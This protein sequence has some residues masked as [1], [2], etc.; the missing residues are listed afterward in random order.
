MSTPNLLYR[1][2]TCGQSRYQIDYYKK[3]VLIP[4]QFIVYHYFARRSRKCHSS[5][6]QNFPIITYIR[7]SCLIPRICRVF[8]LSQYLLWQ[9]TSRY[10]NQSQFNLF[11][12]EKL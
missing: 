8:Q 11:R 1:K 12:L 9:F 10:L 2:Q 6:I 3:R 4:N 7:K 5:D